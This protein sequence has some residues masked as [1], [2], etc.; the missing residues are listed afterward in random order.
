[1]SNSLLQRELHK[2]LGGRAH[3]L[4]SL[5]E[6]DHGK[7]HPLKVLDH[8]YRTPPVK[9]N[10]L[11]IELFTQFLDELFNIPV[12]DDISFGCMDPSL[13]QVSYITWSRFTLRGRVSSGSQKY[14]RMQYLSWS[15]KGGNTSTK[16]V[17]SVVL[18]RSSP[19]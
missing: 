14:G 9:G 4:E 15:S 5:S 6:W 17:M 16:A 12:V 1:M 13:A 7:A 8:L 10:F 11:Y 18:E 2:L 19:P 3:V